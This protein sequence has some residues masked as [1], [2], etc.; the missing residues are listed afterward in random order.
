LN[1]TSVSPQLCIEGNDTDAVT[2][3]DSLICSNISQ[4][5]CTSSLKYRWQTVPACMWCTLVV[6]L[7][8]QGWPYG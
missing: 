6:K 4:L 1:E 8:E 5:H 2:R 3:N 7:C